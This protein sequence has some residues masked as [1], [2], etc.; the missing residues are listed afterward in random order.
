MFAFGLASEQINNNLVR[1]LTCLQQLVDLDDAF[2]GVVQIYLVVTMVTRVH[3]QTIRD[4]KVYF[5][6][7]LYLNINTLIPPF[8]P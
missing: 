7:P 6:P 5:L 3:L 8:R 2:H 1:G 4:S